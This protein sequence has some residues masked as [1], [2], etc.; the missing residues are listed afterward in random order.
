MKLITKTLLASAILLS[1]VAYADQPVLALS[2]SSD[3][4]GFSRSIERRNSS[5]SNTFTIDFMAGSEAVTALNFDIQVQ[6][7]SEKGVDIS[8]CT[9]GL[10]AVGFVGQCAFNAGI[11]KVVGFS[12]SG[13]ALSTATIGSIKIPGSAKIISSSVVM[14]D[15][16]GKAIK[17]EVL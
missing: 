8:G 11:I 15:A 3:S 7:R 17:S 5:A 2:G 6:A 16:A 1:S 4:S 9:S 12:P 13:A 10:Q 14:G